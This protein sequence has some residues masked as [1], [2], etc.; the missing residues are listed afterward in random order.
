MS[1]LQVQ[2]IV[3]QPTSNLGIVTALS[4]NVAGNITATGS[5]ADSVGDVRTITLS[6]KSADYTLIASDNGKFISMSAG[7]VTIPAGIFTAGQTVTI[8]NNSS[9]NQTITQGS[10]IIMYLAGT[11][12][13]GNRTLPKRGLATVVCVA[14]NIFVIT[15]SGLT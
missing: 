12:T 8:Y 3:G 1:T 15:G 2:N 14:L 5:I 4:A 10:G 13:I 9:V 11:E 7:S 6:S